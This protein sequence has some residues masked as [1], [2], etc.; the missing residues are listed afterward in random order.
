MNKENYLDKYK[1]LT[2]ICLNLTNNCN[3]QCKYCFVCQKP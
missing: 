2:N 3:L 1:Y